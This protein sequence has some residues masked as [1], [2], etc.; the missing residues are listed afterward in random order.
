[1]KNQ[2]VLEWSHKTNNFH[3]QPLE[4]HLSTNQERFIDNQR[5]A[6]WAIIF[7]GTHDAVTEMADHWRDRLKLREV[8]KS[9]ADAI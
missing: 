3:I 7:M 2:Y 8:Q 5:T 9:L 6:E 1:M 4:Q